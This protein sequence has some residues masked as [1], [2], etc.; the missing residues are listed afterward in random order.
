MGHRAGTKENDFQFP[1]R[2]SE[3]TGFSRYS[4]RSCLFIGKQ[5]C[6]TTHQLRDI[7]VVPSFLRDKGGREVNVFVKGQQEGSL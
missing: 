5:T 6:L 1:P 2:V 4:S 7:W 3:C